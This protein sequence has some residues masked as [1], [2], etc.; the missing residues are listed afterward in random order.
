MLGAKEIGVPGLDPAK[1]E[2]LLP[3]AL[4]GLLGTVPVERRIHHGLRQQ[5]RMSLHITF[6]PPTC[7]VFTP[8][9]L[10]SLARAGRLPTHLSERHLSGRFMATSADESAR[11]LH[12]HL[13]LPCAP[14]FVGCL[15]GTTQPKDLRTIKEFQTVLFCTPSVLKRK[16][17]IC[18]GTPL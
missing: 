12:V 2:I 5:S 1:N 14:R 10:A 6:W 13:R 17:E 8:E 16:R 11:V 18:S 3:I 4:H 9:V 7:N 15:E